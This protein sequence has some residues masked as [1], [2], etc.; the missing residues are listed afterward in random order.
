[1]GLPM[2]AKRHRRKTSSPKSATWEFGRVPKRIKS[3]SGGGRSSLNHQRENPSSAVEGDQHCNS[4]STLSRTRDAG[5]FLQE[6]SKHRDGLRARRRAQV[7]FDAGDLRG[8][9]KKMGCAGMGILPARGCE[10]SPGGTVA[11]DCASGTG[12][13]GEDKKHHERLVQP[14][15]TVG[16]DG[17]ESNHAS[18]PERQTLEHSNRS[19][20]G[21]DSTA[22]LVDQGTMSDCGNSRCGK[23][24]ARGRTTGIEVGGC[25]LRKTRI[26]RH[27]LCFSAGC[28][29]LQNGSFAQGDSHESRDC[30]HALEM[31]TRNSISKARG[32]DLRQPTQSGSPTVLARVAVQGARKTCATESGH[33]CKSRLAHLAAQFWNLDESQWRRPQDHPRTAAPRN[34]QGHSRHLHTSGNAG[35]AG[36]SSKSCEADHGGR[37]RIEI[38]RAIHPIAYWTQTDP[39]SKGPN[40]VNHLECWRPRRDLNPCYRRERAMS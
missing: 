34:V 20:G 11:E 36:R 25:Q 15:H 5:H 24:F 39:D 7:L 30:R 23:R 40:P 2:V 18:S 35:E 3:T 13:Q 9:P 16:M 31:E 32:L 19:I 37:S 29:S 1:M 8:L 17:Q 28:H 26:E 33:F 10:S 21:R 6:A 22:L 38:T 4:R 27:P 14:C 12:Q